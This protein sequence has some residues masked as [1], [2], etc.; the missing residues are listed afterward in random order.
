MFP[1]VDARDP[2]GLAGQSALPERRPRPAA[3]VFVG[4][5]VGGEVPYVKGEEV[6]PGVAQRSVRL[7]VA[8]YDPARD[9]VDKQ[10]VDGLVEELP[11]AFLVLPEG[12]LGPLARCNVANYARE[13]DIILLRIS[14]RA[15]SNG[16][17]SPL[18]R[19]PASS[20]E[21]LPTTCASPVSL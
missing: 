17:S 13:Q 12:E 16:N 18:L 9:V 7:F 10:R 21:S 19:R 15:S 20:T 14:P 4:D 3:L 6:L 11:K 2:A 5:Q 8:V 1:L